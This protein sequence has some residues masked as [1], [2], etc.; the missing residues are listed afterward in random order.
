MVLLACPPL[1]P[2]RPKAMVLPERGEPGI[3]PDSLR[4]ILPL[5]VSPNQASLS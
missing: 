1:D 4:F 5:P 2:V 3:R